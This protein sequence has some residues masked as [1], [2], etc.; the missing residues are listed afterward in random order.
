[1]ERRTCQKCYSEINVSCHIHD[2]GLKINPELSF[3]GASSDGKV[4]D[5]GTT[6]ILEIKCPYTARDMDLILA[7]STIPSFCLSH[8]AGTLTIKKLMITTFR[9]KDNY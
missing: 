7:A 1:M 5:S 3:L 4:C 9:F 6:G 2:C 8:S